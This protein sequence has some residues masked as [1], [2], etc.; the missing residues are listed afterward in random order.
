MLQTQIFRVLK[1]YLLLKIVVNKQ[2]K[3]SIRVKISNLITAINN[4][5]NKN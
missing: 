3:I 1:R 4:S 2:I 5:N